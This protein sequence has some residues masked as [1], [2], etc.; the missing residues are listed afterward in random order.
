MQTLTTKQ[1]ALILGV[2]ASRVRQFVLAGRLSATKPG[3]DLVLDR[4]EVEAFK[5]N[6]HS[7]KKTI[8]NVES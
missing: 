8:D 2:N 5:I 6:R 3:R 7:Y 4:A 1:A